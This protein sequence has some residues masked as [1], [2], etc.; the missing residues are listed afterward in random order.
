MVVGE[1]V[2]LLATC[3]LALD[4]AP[5]AVG[6]NVTVSVADCPG[7]RIVPFETPLALNS[8]LEVTPETVM[9]EFPL[10][11]SVEV[12]WLEL[13]TLIV[14]KLKLAGLAVRIRVAATPVPL[15][16]IV[17]DEGAP[18]VV[19]AMEPVTLVADTGVKIAFKVALAPAAIVVDVVIPELLKPEAD[20][21][22]L[23]CENVRSALPAL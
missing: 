15:K 3:M 2:A 1:P 16:L 8:A 6:A 7:V 20:P 17:T 5:P 11:V 19:S 23:T 18:L 21:V 14:P 10:F 22:V 12:S 9:L 13:F 4:T